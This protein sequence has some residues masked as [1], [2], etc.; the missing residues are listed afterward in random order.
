MD[1]P[2]VRVSPAGP[3]LPQAALLLLQ[4]P[5]VRGAATVAEGGGVFP[6]PGVA[7]VLETAVV[8]GPGLGQPGTVLV[9]H[10]GGVGR[11]V[12]GPGAT[13]GPDGHVTLRTDNT[14]LDQDQQSHGWRVTH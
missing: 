6:P 9:I 11:H 13:T 7:H 5:A 12:A 2:P 14:E 3:V 8:L 4:A 1:V 10:T